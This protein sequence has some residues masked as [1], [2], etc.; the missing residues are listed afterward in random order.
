MYIYII[1]VYLYMYIYIMWFTYSFGFVWT[2]QL[3]IIPMISCGMEQMEQ[4][5]GKSLQQKKHEAT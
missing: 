1:Y 5:M 3:F 4:L 2:H